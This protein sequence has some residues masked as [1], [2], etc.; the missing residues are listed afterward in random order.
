MPEQA[1]PAA[2][3][4]PR[5][6]RPARG[7]RRLMGL[8][9]SQR[10]LCVPLPRPPRLPRRRRRL[11]GGACLPPSSE[12]LITA[13]SDHWL[14]ARRV[15]GVLGARS[16]PAPKNLCAGRFSRRSS[17]R[18]ACVRDANGPYSP[19]RHCRW[20]C[21]ERTRAWCAAAHG[22]TTET[23]HAVRTAT[24]T[25]PTTATTTSAFGWCVSPTSAHACTGR[26]CPPTTVGGRGAGVIDGSGKSC[27][28]G[29]P[30][31]SAGAHRRAHTEWRRPSGASPGAPHLI[32]PLA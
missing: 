4:R 3:W 18:S 20:G 26:Q 24:T 8:Q 25:T 16:A 29:A 5:Q 2:R 22:T 12:P 10:S 23:T 30:A 32:G 31:R 7:A 1:R 9:P 28:H 21:L 13:F 6:R 11:S 27:P 15:S 19:G 17:R 14:S